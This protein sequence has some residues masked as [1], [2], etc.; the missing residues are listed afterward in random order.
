[1]NPRRLP[2]FRLLRQ[3]GAAMAILAATNISP[4]HAQKAASA[5]GLLQVSELEAALG[6]KASGKPSGTKQAVPGMTLD[7]CSVVL[8][9]SGVNHPVN[10]RIVTNLGMD[11]A[12]AIKIRNMGQARETQWRTPGAKYEQATV[13]SVICTLSGRPSVASHTTCSLPRGEGYLEI[14]VVG[15][16]SDLPSMETVGA[17]V[18]KASTRL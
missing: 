14:D 18:K 11:G 2:S 13:G 10:I 6:G 7:E 16:V 1:M 12:Q 9:G 4:V 5:C 15:S 8:T 3:F 17:L